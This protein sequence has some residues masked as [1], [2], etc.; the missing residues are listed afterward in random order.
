M[1]NKQII[2]L[3][4]S[5]SSSNNFLFSDNFISFESHLTSDDIYGFGERIH[6][7]K[8]EEGIYTIW[9]VDRPNFYDDGK[10]SKNLYGHQPIGLHKTKN[11]L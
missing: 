2:F 11:N 4:K 1:K 6:E 9:P 7:F 8:L 10:G 3:Y 5:V